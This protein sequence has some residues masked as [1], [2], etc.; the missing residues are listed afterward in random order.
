MSQD[1]A[2]RSHLEGSDHRSRHAVLPGH[3]YNANDN[4]FVDHMQFHFES[5]VAPDPE[6]AQLA[7]ARLKTLNLSKKSI[8]FARL[9]Y[10][11]GKTLAQTAAALNMSSQGAQARQGILLKHVKNRLIRL[12]VWAEIGDAIESDCT[13]SNLII[14]FHYRDLMSVGEIAEACGVAYGTAQFRIQ[15]FEVAMGLKSNKKA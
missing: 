11:E 4:D 7:W 13:Y 15:R 5:M 3:Q 9:Y 10:K 14:C 2:G 8:D 6:A 1:H 12:G